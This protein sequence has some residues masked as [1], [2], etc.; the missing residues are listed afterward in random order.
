MFSFCWAKYVLAKAN[1]VKNSSSILGTA[2]ISRRTT[3]RWV[4]TRMSGGGGSSLCYALGMTNADLQLGFRPSVLGSSCGHSDEF[5]LLISAYEH[6][7]RSFHH[8]LSVCIKEKSKTSALAT[9]PPQM[10]AFRRISF[11][12][13]SLMFFFFKKK[14]LNNFSLFWMTLDSQV[15][16][17]SAREM[18]APSNINPLKICHKND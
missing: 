9:T 2:V 5:A 18:S 10:E 15:E 4:F 16:N 6:I 14:I 13:V 3:G 17:I 8:G 11:Q 1:A 12:G 7:P